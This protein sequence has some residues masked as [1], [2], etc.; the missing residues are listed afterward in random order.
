MGHF[1]AWWTFS[2][3][4]H[5]PRL[6]ETCS[7]PCFR[8]SPFRRA[9]EAYL[10]RCEIRLYGNR[11]I[12]KLEIWL[13]IVAVS[14]IFAGIALPLVAFFSGFEIYSEKIRDAFWGGALVPPE[15]E[16][17]QRWIVALF[18]PTIAS[19]GVL[20]AYLVRSAMRTNELWPWNAILLSL[21]AWAPTDIAISLMRGFW[22]HVVIDLFVVTVIAVPTL[23]VRTQKAAQSST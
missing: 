2:L 6:T 14:H 20:M 5:F 16:A 10:V 3:L 12:K 18:G 1:P 13:F 15:A 11:V 21:L 19:W 9:A 8:A 4:P 23:I 7:R 17:F 22:L